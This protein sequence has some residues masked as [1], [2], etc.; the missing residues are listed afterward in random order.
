MQCIHEWEAQDNTRNTGSEHGDMH[1]FGDN[2]ICENTILSTIRQG[3]GLITAEFEHGTEFWESQKLCRHDSG[4]CH[5]W[6]LAG[7]CQQ[8]SPECYGT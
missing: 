2:K 6:E 3:W 5:D 4:G 1:R 8:M 7:V